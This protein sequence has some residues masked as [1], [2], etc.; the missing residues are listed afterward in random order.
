MFFYQKGSF[1]PAVKYW[2]R[3]L[4]LKPDE[5]MIQEYLS[6]CLWVIGKK[7]KSLEILDGVIEKNQNDPDV[8]ADVADLFLQFKEK[9]RLNDCLERLKDIA[10]SNPK[11]LRISGEIALANKETKKAISLYEKSFRIAPEDV[12]TIRNLGSVFMNNQMWE[13]YIKLY[14]KALVYHPNNPDFLSRMGEVLISCPVISL[15]N[16]EEGK[17]YSERAF[18][19]YNCTPD[20]LIASGSHLAYAYAMLGEKQNAITTISQTINIG[21][22]EKIA[23][24]HQKRLENLLDA[25]Q[26]M[27]EQ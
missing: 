23:D 21:R 26:N 9:E 11:L 12:K 10:P 17:T 4:E 16:Y 19:F 13:E 3:A 6:K 2:T 7:E 18:T 8:L 20:V 24:S 1:T 22:R 15:R 14:K 27:D 25:F 5:T